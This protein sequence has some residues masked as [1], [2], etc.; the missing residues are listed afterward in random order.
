MGFLTP[1]NVLNTYLIIIS[2]IIKVEVDQFKF[3]FHNH[4]IKIINILITK[5]IITT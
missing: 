1:P 4:N 2:Q 5:F 3:I